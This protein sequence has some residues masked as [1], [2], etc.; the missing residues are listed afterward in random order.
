MLS[1]MTRRL[2][3]ARVN[4]GQR[5]LAWCMSFAVAAGATAC[6]HRSA[7]AGGSRS[8]E[9]QAYLF[10]YFTRNGEDGVHLAYSH[11]GI[12]WTALNGGKSVITPAID[13]AGRGWQEWNTRAALMRDPSI[14][15]GPDGMFHLVW[16]VAWTDHAIGV[17]HSRDLIHWS[18]QERVP[19]ME[20]EPNVLN[21]WAPDLF[22]DDATQQFVIVWASSIPGRF[23]SH[24]LA[25][26]ADVARA[27]RP[28]AVLRHH[29]RLQG[30]LTRR[31]ALR[32]RLLCDRWNDH[33]PRRYLLSRDEGRN[34]FPKRAEH[35]RRDQRPRHG[36]IWPGI[37]GVHRP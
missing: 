10:S 14:L 25:C 12:S 2:C 29:E 18:E 7:G 1:C 5:R 4:R 8:A 15:R 30:V 21:T 22:Y 32:R 24:R 19:V 6:L 9:S 11:D 36:S 35:P 17:A 3:P 28:P 16:T 33:P 31:A 27:R 34:V 13:G 23:P 20:H 37:A 26:P